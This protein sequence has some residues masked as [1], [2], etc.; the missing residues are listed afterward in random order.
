MCN[1]VNVKVKYLRPQYQDL[2]EWCEDPNNV[3]IGRK[4]IVFVKRGDSKYRYPKQDSIWA[5]PF[6]ITDVD[7][8]DSVIAKYKSYII[9]E[10]RDGRITGNDLR[11]L[12]GKNLG[13]W[14][15][16]HDKYV[17]CHGD[18]LVDLVNEFAWTQHNF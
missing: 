6:K 11:S 16:E 18:V 17:R 14:C 13:C 2:E 15:K 4:G 8:R 10:I 3:Y 12:I 5:N 1:V 7:D 9:K